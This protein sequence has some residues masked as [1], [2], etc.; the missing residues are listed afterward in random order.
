MSIV[1][2]KV[3]YKTMK[4]NSREMENNCRKIIFME[5]QNDR[6]KDL[7]LYGNG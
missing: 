6:F 7:W 3:L 5:D 4:S 2:T 1:Q